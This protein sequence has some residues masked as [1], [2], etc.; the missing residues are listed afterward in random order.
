MLIDDFKN[1]LV[2]LTTVECTYNSLAFNTF[3]VL[4]NHYPFQVPKHLMTLKWKP[5]TH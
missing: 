1:I 4:C 5:C 2:K 3:T